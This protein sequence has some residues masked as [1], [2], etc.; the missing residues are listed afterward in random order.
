MIFDVRTIFTYFSYLF[1]S[2]FH[3]I[4]CFFHFHIIWKILYLP[5]FPIFSFLIVAKYI[6]SKIYHHSYLKA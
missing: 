3:I 6:Y 5:Y 4:C 1:M 2:S